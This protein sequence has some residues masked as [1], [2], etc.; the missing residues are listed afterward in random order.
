MITTN[1]HDD[2]F[3]IVAGTD[4][5][6]SVI[7]QIYMDRSSNEPGLV[8]RIDGDDEEYL[9]DDHLEAAGIL[10]RA[11]SRTLTPDSLDKIAALSRCCPDGF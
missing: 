5:T 2:G 7:G 3:D 10:E 9:P 4:I 6:G 8:L 1:A 11:T